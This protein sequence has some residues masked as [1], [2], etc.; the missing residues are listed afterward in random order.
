M[1]K[2]S[3]GRHTRKAQLKSSK[4]A[5]SLHKTNPLAGI[6]NHC[7]EKTID[8]LLDLIK[9][10]FKTA[11]HEQSQPKADLTHDSNIGLNFQFMI[12]TLYFVIYEL[13]LIVASRPVRNSIDTLLENGGWGTCED[14]QRSSPLPLAIVENVMF[15]PALTHFY[16]CYWKL[17][18]NMQNDKSAPVTAL[19]A[20]LYSG[21]YH[22]AF[23]SRGHMDECKKNFTLLS[24]VTLID[25]AK[26]GLG[27]AYG[28]VK[29]Q[30]V[31]PHR[32]TE[33][34]QRIQFL[35]LLYVQMKMLGRMSSWRN[36]YSAF[37]KSITADIWEKRQKQAI[38]K[39]KMEKSF[40]ERCPLFDTWPNAG[41]SAD[42]L[43][44]ENSVLVNEGDIHTFYHKK[45][46]A[47]WCLSKLE[48]GQRVSSPLNPDVDAFASMEDMKR[49]NPIYTRKCGISLN[50]IEDLA[51]VMVTPQGQVYKASGEHSIIPWL[52]E[53]STDPNTREHLKTQD[54]KQVEKKQLLKI[55]DN[56]APQP[57]HPSAS[58]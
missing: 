37:K 44:S 41:F 42:A 58:P 31:V 56:M 20:Q 4:Q 17:M 47:L 5:S 34:I 25:L 16:S 33:A 12:G 57:S 8:E 23:V 21:V 45:N 29:M 36:S 51:D 49:P 46:W 32:A 43:N 55:I 30:D 6:S 50:D 48:S 19:D 28:A 9:N 15:L 35:I 52:L 10:N 53:H 54:L 2:Q 38:T 39:I 1:T 3:R 24:L 14:F 27:C 40:T 11:L 26:T 22:D 13:A 18:K 7:K